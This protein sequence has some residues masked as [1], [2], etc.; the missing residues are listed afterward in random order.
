MAG[1]MNSSKEHATPSHE[2]F[3]KETP[4]KTPLQRLEREAMASAKK[5]QRTIKKHEEQNQIFTK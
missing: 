2:V 3:E 1:I 5:A 4:A